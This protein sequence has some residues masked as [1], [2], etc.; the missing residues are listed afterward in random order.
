MS[1]DEQSEARTGGDPPPRV[2]KIHPGYLAWIRS[3]TG[4][5][6]RKAKSSMQAVREGKEPPHFWPTDSEGEYL[7]AEGPL[8]V[9]CG[10]G[11]E[12]APEG[13]VKV[14]SYAE[15][16]QLMLAQIVVEYSVV[17]AHELVDFIA[18]NYYEYELAFWPRDGLTER[19]HDEKR[20]A[21]LTRKII[22]LTEHAGVE[23]EIS[24]TPEGHVHYVT[25]GRRSPRQVRA[26]GER[27]QAKD[28][29][30]APDRNRRAGHAQAQEAG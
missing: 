1:S 6:F 20:N 10:D 9:Y 14:T 16:R 5:D 22:E 18:S 19:L 11:F 24:D 3:S 28:R 7:P 15:L 4:K 12:P 25:R 27:G 29:N 21:D 30:Y 26:L 13:W 2:P 17:D 8:R 23:L